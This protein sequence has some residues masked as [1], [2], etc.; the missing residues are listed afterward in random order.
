MEEAFE[1]RIIQHVEPV[2][3]ERANYICQGIVEGAKD[4]P[5]REQLWAR[6]LHGNEF[7]M[8]CI[9]YFLY[10][11]A[12]GDVVTLRERDIVDAV[13]RRSGR[14]VYR[15]WLA[16]EMVDRLQIH[17]D[18]ASLGALQEWRTAN[19]CSIDAA[20]AAVSKAV[21]HYLTERASKRELE[22]EGGSIF[23]D[24]IT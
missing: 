7:E 20:D 24:E 16:D 11:L 13:V 12:L 9:P 15:I 19:L 8:C 22:F 14:S 1:H 17:R 21:M 5:M 4:P 3:R 23:P 2:W 10:N 6:K 18:L